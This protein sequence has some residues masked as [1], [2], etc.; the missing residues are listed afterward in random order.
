MSKIVFLVTLVLFVM[1]LAMGA[2]PP[3]LGVL[4]CGFAAG[5]LC[6]KA[7]QALAAYR[8]RNVLNRIR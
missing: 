7:E 8:A 2:I 6:S 5:F 1:G 3:A 4:V